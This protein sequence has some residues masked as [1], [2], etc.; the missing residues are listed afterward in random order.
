MV[1]K[2]TKVLVADDDPFVRDML[3][4]ILETGD[5][6]V[7]TAQNGADALLK[8]MAD[9]EIGLIIS[10][11]N[12]PEMNGLELIT[13]LREAKTDTPIIILTGNSEISVA[14]NAINSG[15]NDYLLKDENIQDTVLL[16]VEKVLEKHNLKKQ[17]VQ[18]MADLARENA[19]L[20]K[21][22]ALAQK[23][24]KNILPKHLQFKGL[25]I[26][27]FYRPSDM[28]GGDFFDAWESEGCV[29]FLIG[30]VSGHSTSSALV[31]AVCK[32]ILQSLGYTMTDPLEIIV[33][34][35]HMLCDIV[36]D[37][38]MFLSLIY[39]IFEQGKEDMRIVSAGH[40]PIFIANIDSI[41]KINSTGPVLGWDPND[42]WEIMTVQFQVGASLVMYTDGLTE[43]KDA[44]GEE[45]GEDR[46]HRLLEKIPSTGK[47]IS[48]IF[49]EVNTFCSS[50]FSDDLT[51]F[52]IKR[53]KTFE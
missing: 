27:T 50:V 46:L 9:P 20:E 35:N 30:D 29:H 52:V 10:D 2:Q 5:Y 16:S 53:E 36:G 42:S 37:S 48:N 44:T 41:E 34:A 7:E 15:A 8:Y 40:N 25:E 14:I 3:A 28:I 32:G 26:G 31:M 4:M 24:Q 22:K 18:L 13:K 39:G 38:G 11:M 1:E 19:R 21:E 43:A 33:T 6:L 45:F 47:L 51:L 49:D 23:V 17:N 12:M